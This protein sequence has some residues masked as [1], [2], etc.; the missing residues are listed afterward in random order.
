MTP[1]L[2]LISLVSLETH[3]MD[4]F[5]PILKTN[6]F[7]A[8]HAESDDNYTFLYFHNKSV[9]CSLHTSE[10]TEAKM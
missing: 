2:L 9:T 8:S 7:P 5:H 1:H 10:G 4:F 3:D 6:I